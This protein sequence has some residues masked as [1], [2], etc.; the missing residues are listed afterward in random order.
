MDKKTALFKLGRKQW[1]QSDIDKFMESTR[2]SVQRTIDDV[3]GVSVEE[4]KPK[5]ILREG[6]II[7]T[8]DDG[9]LILLYCGEKFTVSIDHPEL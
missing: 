1:S 6:E 8:T 3:L 7:E 2:Q 9:D 4:M 5:N